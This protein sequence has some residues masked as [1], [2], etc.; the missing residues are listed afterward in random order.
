MRAL[1]YPAIGVGG[2][3]HVAVQLLRSLSPTEVIAVDVAEDEREHAREVGA[4]HAIS[5][6]RLAR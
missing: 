2:L 6:G 1:Q 3:G 5:A 4:H